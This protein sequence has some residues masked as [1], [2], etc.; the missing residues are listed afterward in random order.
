[1]TDLEIYNLLIKIDSGY[2]PSAK[3]YRELNA[4]KK[5]E[6][7]S[8]NR[9]PASIVLLK[10]V[11]M[12]SIKESYG[13][14]DLSV[15]S[16]LNS[17][18]SLYLSETGINDISGL[19]TLTTLENLDLSKTI[20]SDISA[21]S[22]LTSII[23]LN[24]S[25]TKV[26]DISTLS[27]LTCLTNLNLSGDIY[28][29]GSITDISVLR[30]L[31]QLIHLD[32][33]FNPNLFE[34]N[35][36]SSLTSLNSL[37]LSRT[38]VRDISALSNLVALTDLRLF[39]RPL[40]EEDQI[41]DI[42]PLKGLIALTHL[43]LSNNKT[44]SKISALSGLTNLNSLELRNTEVRDIS[45]LSSLTNLNSLDLSETGVRDISALSNLTKLRSLV[46]TSTGVN[47]INAL[48]NLTS[49][50]TLCL[51]GTNIRDLPDWIG[52]L[53]HLKWL[54]LTDLTLT[55]LPMSLLSLKLEYITKKNHSAR[56]HSGILISGLKLQRQPISLFYNKRALIERYYYSEKTVLNEAKVIFMGDGGAGKS[57]TIQR[58]LNKGELLR[59][60]TEVTHD[61]EIGHWDNKDHIVK[62]SGK[63]DF[64]DF[65]GQDIY[66]SMH[67]CFLTE[68]SCY[69]I[70]ISNRQ[71]NSQHDLMR[72]ARY[73]LHNI[74]AFA[75]DSPILIAVN[76]WTGLSKEGVSIRQLQKE[77]PSIN[78]YDQVLYNA[79]DRS[80]ERFIEIL[81][82]ICD[83]AKRAY[84]YGMMFPTSWLILRN[85][86]TKEYGGRDYISETEYFLLAEK[87]MR[88]YDG[89]FSKETAQWL[90]NWFNDLGTCFS[91]G[92]ADEKNSSNEEYKVL[93][94]KWVIQA[95]YALVNYNLSGEV[96][97][98]IPK[99]EGVP[100]LENGCI[101]YRQVV[102]ILNNVDYSEGEIEYILKILR[103]MKLSYP[104][105]LKRQRYEF[106]PALC[107]AHADEYEKEFTDK[108]YIKHIHYMLQF[109]F[110]PDTLLQKIM[111]RTYENGLPPYSVWKEG[112]RIDFYG[113][114]YEKSGV[115]VVITQSNHQILQIETFS[116]IDQPTSN[117]F[118]IVRTWITE[119]YENLG[120]IPQ[121]EYVLANKGKQEAHIPLS[122]LLKARINM[123]LSE[124]YC[125]DGGEYECYLI[126]DLLD[127]LYGRNAASKVRE[128]TI[129][130]EIDKITPE[131]ISRHIT[132][133]QKCEILR[134]DEIINGVIAHL[135]SALMKMHN[136]VLDFKGLDEPHLTADIQE[137]IDDIINYKY[138]LQI[139]R[140]YTLG[141]ASKKLGKADL[142]FYRYENGIFKP[143][144]ILE[145]KN[146]E[147]FGT[148]QYNQL[149]GYLNQDYLCGITI[150]INRKKIWEDATEFILKNLY[151]MDGPFSPIRIIRYKKNNRIT[152]IRSEHIMDDVGT[153]MPIYHLILNLYDKERQTIAEKARR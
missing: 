14:N 144:F 141:H 145:N 107:R 149:I 72:Q 140:E 109:S 96:R 71:R 80:K 131:T 66:L 62:Y 21:L 81:E 130:L 9:L 105:V 119:T 91:Y 53:S 113:K 148:E 16:N 29:S 128:K 110:L 90:L 60:D 114:K 112:V 48:V 123:G 47:D 135:R 106:I 142:F 127:G 147:K 56:E 100:I 134:D 67:K 108:G 138:G 43:N 97:A 3:E 104:V 73:W 42:N 151:R 32:L 129:E 7:V 1:M 146:L 68:R 115:T 49:L 39:G 76:T 82:R 33:S 95:M 101:P 5:I 23:N 26:S 93:N 55:E 17:L 98:T 125:H 70:V 87:C 86:M 38:G 150:S 34:I 99:P 126:D 89:F 133:E 30:G 19:A 136:R 6:F 117:E 137:R 120:M 75:G 22:N 35:A 37:D 46:L 27:V 85:A 24:L 4:V 111:I 44:L 143:F 94:P 61:I 132:Q 2:T 103:K 121:E 65:G 40:I 57:Y 139:S 116:D 36:L 15:L 153:I 92:V 88:K 79:R 78:I 31:K 50:E 11:S 8:I 77:F 54:V 118:S 10:N 122:S 58:I 63:I 18:T 83:M 20:V 74:S 69:V 28:R 51:G 102:T 59:E 52:G 152:Y 13:F 64:W 45:A 84:S 12:L 41:T 124:F 25:G